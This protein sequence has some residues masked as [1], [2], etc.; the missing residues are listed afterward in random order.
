MF[1]DLNVSQ[2][3]L[4][5]NGVAALAFVGLTLFIVV[6]VRAWH[7]AFRWLVVATS[8]S[9]LWFVLLI[10]APLSSISGPTLDIVETI[11]T[12][13]WLIVAA[14]IL[15]IDARAS[16]YRWT[17]GAAIVL[18]TVI[19]A[20]LAA[21]ASPWVGD[22]ATGHSI[23]FA[24]GAVAMSLF[25]L[26]LVEQTYRTS[27]FDARWAV[28]YLCVALAT[29]F[30]YDFV[31]YTG[32]LVAHHISLTVWSARGAI[33]AV[34]APLIALA[35]ARNAQW[36]TRIS[37]SHH[38]IFR[39]GT[40]IA[41]G[42]YLM[43]VAGGSTY[44]RRFD[45]SW[46]EFA[47]LLFAV[48]ASML[49]AVLLLSG[50]IRSHAR[51]LL[52]KH[53]L[54]Y[55]YDYREQWLSLTRR[56]GR[57][58][59]DLDV[60]DRAI[61]AI[62]QPVDSPAGALWLDRD[63]RFV[64]VAD[65]NMTGAADISEPRD[66]SI[67]TYLAE[68][69]WVID[70]L[71]YTSN[72]AKYGQM[73]LPNWFVELER[74]RL[75]IPLLVG[76]Q[77]LIGFMVLASPRAAF[78]LGWEEIDLLKAFAQ[79]VAVYL[80]Y[81]EANRAL[82]Q[83]RQFEAFNRLTAFLMHDLKNIAG[84]QSLMLQNAAKH[85]DNPAFVDDMIE[86][87][88]MSVKRMRGLLN[89]LQKVSKAETRA[90]RVAV[91]E[92]VEAVISELAGTYPEPVRGGQSS[93]AIIN[94]DRD[95]LV[96]MLRHLARNAQDATGA[97]GRVEIASELRDGSVAITVTDDGEGMTPAFIRDSLFQP[98]VSTKSARGMGI[99][100]YQVRDFAR[101]AGGEVIVDSTPG[102]GTRFTIVLP[103]VADSSAEPLTNEGRT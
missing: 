4:L 37:V 46:A 76:Q 55:R 39:T 80:D 78:D 70:R 89:Q 66:S 14:W 54:P 13:L 15:P 59:G 102:H 94:A 82:T 5:A 101:A 41:A 7:A 63:D 77:R 1:P 93:G 44:I 49:L 12:G 85:K 98:F 2:L 97:A 83:A 33:N 47:A 9:A 24:A 30:I 74:S 32:A 36:S 8:V 16:A 65:W 43:I 38:V 67:A 88:D 27:G 95:R 31:M 48:M 68:T 18:P 21:R 90:E 57:D 51:V 53:L 100:A 45:S 64:C 19:L 10:V 96:M 84:Q 91:D 81:Q 58:D 25:G 60:Y 71:D 92:A 62:A 99:G 61:Q 40:L 23:V 3:W 26:V 72:P 34:A 52:H 69:G 6:V 73:V 17:R 29:L 56:L 79:Q 103:M 28:K 50:Q 86:T 75:L 87:I 20:L 35:A 11:R 42:L 22:P